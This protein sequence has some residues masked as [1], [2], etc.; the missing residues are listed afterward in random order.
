MSSDSVFAQGDVFAQGNIE[1]REKNYQQAEYYYRIAV[2]REPNNAVIINALGSSIMAQKRYADAYNVFVTAVEKDTNFFTTFWNLAKSATFQYKDSLA[3][4]WYERYIRVA[5][6][7]K[8]SVT[9]AHWE[10]ILLYERLLKS[11]GIT[12]SQYYNLL[13]HANRFKILFPDAPEIRPLEDFLEKLKTKLPDF[14]TPGQ[15]FYF[16]E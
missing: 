1:M 13:H 12:E 15:R 2:E 3:I 10:I 16:R 14:N 8:I 7:Q 5:E 4:E 6:R 11:T 9:Q